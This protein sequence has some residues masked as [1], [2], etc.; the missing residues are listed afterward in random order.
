MPLLGVGVEGESDDVGVAKR[1]NIT[2][3]SAA[4]WLK[5]IGITRADTSTTF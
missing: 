2:T 4:S 3:V 5:R 1:H